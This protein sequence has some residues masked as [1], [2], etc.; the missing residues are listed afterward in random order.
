MANP[1][2]TYTQETVGTYRAFCDEFTSNT[3]VCHGF[4][5]CSAHQLTP[6]SKQPLHIQTVYTI[7]FIPESFFLNSTPTFW[8]SCT[9][10]SHS[11]PKENPKTNI[12]TFI[13]SHTKERALLSSYPDLVLYKLMV[14]SSVSLEALAVDNRW[15][16]LVVFLLGDPHL[17]EGREGSKDGATNPYRVFPLGR[18]ND[19]DLHGRWSQGSDLLLHPVSN[20]REHGAAS[21]EDSI[22]IQVLTNVHVALHDRVIS[23]LVDTSRFHSQ[24]A[25]LE[26]GLGASE[27]LIANCDYLTIRKLVALLKAGAA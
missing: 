6:I 8:G 19:L 3:N 27:A 4:C 14:A 18:C 26:K 1:L 10:I 25:G 16:R 2:P 20:A 23:R 15:P 24:E 9:S 22:G 21:R 13:I 5:R 7:Q 12:S 11:P 17:L